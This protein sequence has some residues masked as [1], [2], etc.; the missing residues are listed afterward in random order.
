MPSGGD[1]S[2]EGIGAPPPQQYSASHAGKLGQ[3]PQ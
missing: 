2:A 3:R 1:R